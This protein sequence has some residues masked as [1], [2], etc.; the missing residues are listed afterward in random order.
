M[1]DLVYKIIGAVITVVVAL[2]LVPVIVDSATVA[3]NGA[4]VTIATLLGLV[5]LIFVAGTVLLVAYL[6]FEKHSV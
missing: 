4:S 5:P 6:L 1:E 3:S 2:A